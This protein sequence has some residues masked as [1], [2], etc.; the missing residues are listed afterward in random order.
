MLRK[1]AIAIAASGAMS[2]A[3]VYALGLGEIQLDSALNQPLDARIKLVKASELENWEIKPALASANEFEQAGVERVFFLN[4]L[5]FEVEREGDDV[6]V[7]LSTQ[8]PVVEPFLNFLV[9]VDWPSGRLLREYTLLL[10]PPVF[11][12][13][14]PAEPVAA[15]EQEMPEEPLPGTGVA[16]VPAAETVPVPVPPPVVEEPAFEPT[17]KPEVEEERTYAVRPNDTLWEIALDVRPSRDLTPQQVMLAIQD[18]NP[19]AFISGN[20]NRLKKNQVLRIPSEDQMRGRSFRESVSE[21]AVQNEAVEQRRAQ[22][23]ATRKSQIIDRDDSL[24]DAQLNLVAEGDATAEGERLAGGQVSERAAGSQ[25]KLDQELS[26]ALENLDKSNRENQELRTRLE[27][28]EEQINTLQ[29]LINLKDEQMVALQTGMTPEAKE[30]GKPVS[31]LSAPV[32]EEAGSATELAD[33]QDLNFADDSAPVA[34]SK[35]ETEQPV[36]PAPKAETAATKPTL[37]APRQLPPA[38]PMDFLMENLPLVGGGLSAL[39]LA[40]LGLRAVRNR[41]SEKDEDKEAAFLNDTMEDLSDH[42]MDANTDNLDEEFAD[43]ELGDDVVDGGLSLDGESAETAMPDVGLPD[44]LDEQHHESGDTLG[45]AEMYMAYGRLDRAK[46]LLETALISEAGRTDL[47]MKLLEVMSEQDDSAG[48]A[49]HFDEIVSNG[50]D[51]QKEEANRLRQNLSNPE[52]GAEQELVLDSDLSEGE[53][54]DFS[55][56]ENDN[57]GLSEA[58]ES[59]LDLGSEELDFD[60]DGLELDSGEEAATTSLD[61]DV[62]LDADENA[63]DFELNLDDSTSS[64]GELDLD[65]E[66]PLVESEDDDSM[67]LDFD[68]E[69]S[70]LDLTEGDELPTLDSDLDLELSEELGDEEPSLEFE[71]DLADT[72]GS[73]LDADLGGDLDLTLDEEL[74]TLDM[75]SDLGGDDLSLDS[76]LSLDADLDSDLD[77]DQEMDITLDTSSND[78]EDTLA[79]LDELESELS[80]DLAD[81]ESDLDLDIESDSDTSEDVSLAELEAE[82]DEDISLDIE[83]SDDLE[84]P[85]LE[86]DSDTELSLDTDL[87]VDSTNDQELDL[88]LDVE[89]ELPE[90]TPELDTELSLDDSDV[91]LDLSEDLDLNLDEVESAPELTTEPEEAV[92]PVLEEPQPEAEAEQAASSDNELNLDDLDDDLDFLSGT[93]ESETKLDLARA[94]I[95]MDDKDGAREIL[96]EVIEEGNDGQRQEASK[97]MDSLS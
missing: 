18:E 3:Q 79:Q 54:L 52:A 87:D 42:P 25:S 48:F 5:K 66:A 2:A 44:A 62:S 74:P 37:Q 93:D 24:G 43:L 6:F 88:S 64:E 40:L 75:D 32:T 11:N 20:I 70:G 34:E 85:E 13:E 76:E 31:D 81:L 22:L 41:K 72:T 4:N 36:Q 16:E 84:L 21:V 80:S 89:D 47:R 56:F 91:E 53:E 63:L 46:D 59:E 51:E 38:G 82:L 7:N 55:E 45:E 9:Q 30:V 73:D 78:G 19:E 10:D 61:S 49:E 35:P 27:A 15:P 8:Q 28:L 23:D 92:A 1:L 26:L 90:L 60:L 71:S 17:P 83:G 29:R 96:N 95:D 69:D 94:Y 57:L 65:L 68:V 77:L 86:L 50:S 97:L 12:E 39:L 58:E 14:Q 67:S 33:G